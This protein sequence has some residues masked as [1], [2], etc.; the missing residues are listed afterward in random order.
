MKR[1]E[2]SNVGWK[3]EG[4]NISY[5][6]NTYWK[7]MKRNLKQTLNFYYTLSFEYTF[8]HDF[9]EVYFSHSVPYT[10]TNLLKDIHEIEVEYPH[11]F[12]KQMLCHS[13]AGN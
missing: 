13:L 1:F 9:D 8:E 2:E 3:R 11:Y 6:I 10:F 4:E 7:E 5:Q 12:S